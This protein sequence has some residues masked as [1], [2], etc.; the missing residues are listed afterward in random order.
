MAFRKK[1]GTLRELRAGAKEKG[2]HA[3]NTMED[4]GS[5]KGENKGGSKS[6]VAEIA[7]TIGVVFFQIGVI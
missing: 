3:K 1:N 2:P 7:L 5:A 6:D 4:T